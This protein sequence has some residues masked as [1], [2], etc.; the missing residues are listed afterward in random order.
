MSNDIFYP[1]TLIIRVLLLH[2][3]WL[4]CVADAQLGEEVHEKRPVE[5]FA[6]LVKYKPEIRESWEHIRISI[7]V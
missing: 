5:I 1:Q 7:K 3:R 2:N 4:L 6:Q